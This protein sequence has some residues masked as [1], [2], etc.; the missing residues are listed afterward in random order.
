MLRNFEHVERL[1]MWSD[2]DDDDDEEIRNGES[3]GVERL[4]ME[5]VGMSRD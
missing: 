4:E 5:R 1:E 3:R 2:D